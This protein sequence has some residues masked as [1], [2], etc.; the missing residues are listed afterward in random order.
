MAEAP[1]EAGQMC[2]ETALKDVFKSAMAQDG[3]ARGLHQ[4]CKALEKNDALLCVLADN[5][6]E[7]NYKKVVEALCAERNI[8]LIKVSRVITFLMTLSS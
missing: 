4:C 3:L 8:N 6:D 1:L 5:C 7:P 2:V